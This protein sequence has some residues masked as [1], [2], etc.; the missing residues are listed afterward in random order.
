M[1]EYRL[2]IAA[3]GVTTPTIAVSTPTY[4][5]ITFAYSKDNFTTNDATGIPN[6]TTNI[7]ISHILTDFDDLSSGFSGTVDTN[8][9]YFLV[10]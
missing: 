8:G 6:S 9:H 10:D 2:K 4:S 3:L 5:Q 7:R 1:Y